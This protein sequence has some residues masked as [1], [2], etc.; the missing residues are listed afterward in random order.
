MVGGDKSSNVL[1]PAT[2]L[3]CPNERPHCT[4]QSH[5]L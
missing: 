4:Y 1:K 2:S 3:R 5:K